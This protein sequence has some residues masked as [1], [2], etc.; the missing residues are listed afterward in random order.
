MRKTATVAGVGGKRKKE[1]GG[2]GLGGGGR[3]VMAA[4]YS[5]RCGRKW[6]SQWFQAELKMASP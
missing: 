6:K 2:C 4:E 1:R 5:S 3:V